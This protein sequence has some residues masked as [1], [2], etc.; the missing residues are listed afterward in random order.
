MS[1]YTVWLYVSVCVCMCVFL[2]VSELHSSLEVWVLCRC[3]GVV[4]AQDSSLFLNYQM[5]LHSVWQSLA[6]SPHNL[7]SSMSQ[8][9]IFWDPFILPSLSLMEWYVVLILC[10]TISIRNIDR[11]WISVIY[12]NGLYTIKWHYW[13]YCTYYHSISW[14]INENVSF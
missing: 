6:P 13:V 11:F 14:C 5:S 12:K 4:F 8:I 1:M 9:S 10:L 3:V 2:Y 7:W